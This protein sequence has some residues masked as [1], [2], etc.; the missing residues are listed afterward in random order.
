MKESDYLVNLDRDGDRNKRYA[1]ELDCSVSGCIAV[2]ECCKK[3][4]KFSDQKIRWR[5][6]RTALP[7]IIT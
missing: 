2:T 3:L 5:I 7:Q 6:R 1:Y 4:Q